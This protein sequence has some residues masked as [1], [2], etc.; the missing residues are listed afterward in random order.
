MSPLNPS[1]YGL[2]SLS[3]CIWEG[4]Y[5]DN[6]SSMGSLPQE[7]VFQ[8]HLQCGSFRQDAVLQEVLQQ[9]S[10]LWGSVLQELPKYF[11]TQLESHKLLSSFS[12]CLEDHGVFW[13]D[14]PSDFVMDFDRAG[15]S[16]FAHTGPCLVSVW[17]RKGLSFIKKKQQRIKTPQG[18]VLQLNY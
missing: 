6:C 18:L 16:I 14:P 15:V 4:F 8:E 17:F 10:F 11:S 2:S 12:T 3:F 5:V 7:T 13:E 1:V 9:G